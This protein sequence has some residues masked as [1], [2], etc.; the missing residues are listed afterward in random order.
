MSGRSLGLQSSWN[1]AIRLFTRGLDTDPT[2]LRRGIDVADSINQ[3]IEEFVNRYVVT[4][5][6]DNGDIT[7]DAVGTYTFQGDVVVN[8][9]TELNGELTVL[10]GGITVGDAAETLMVIA[11]DVNTTTAINSPGIR[12]GYS[13]GADDVIGDVVWTDWSTDS[14]PGNN[15]TMSVIARRRIGSGDWVNAYLQAEVF[16]D[17]HD[18]TVNISANPAAATNASG[19][20]NLYGMSKG[21]G[22][23]HITLTADDAVLLTNRILGFGGTGNTDFFQY[24]NTNSEF[25]WKIANTTT[26]L[27]LK[28]DIVY[29][30]RT[31]SGKADYNNLED[32]PGIFLFS[33]NMNTTNKVTPGV[34]FGSSDS[35]FTTEN[36][37]SLAGI[38]GVATEAYG[39]DSD[40]GMYLE[41]RVC[42]NNPGTTNVLESEPHGY[43]MTTTGFR[44]REDNVQD[45][46]S[47]GLRWDDVYATNG[48]IQTSDLREKNLLPQHRLGL[49]FMLSLD[50]IAFTRDGGTR[51]HHGVGAQHVRDGLVSVEANPA[52]HAL[53]V[54]DGDD[55]RMGVRYDELWGPQINANREIDERLSRLEDAILAL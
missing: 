5:N 1:E 41:F 21:T 24:D 2:D 50:G 49:D 17:S 13:G 46:G 37:K 10:A 32:N 34:L 47:S 42:G 7:F 26:P 8:G 18:T 16:D 38:W 4:A 6:N 25:I 3:Q 55:G 35:A 30:R 48:T 28:D 45:L 20:V 40:G 39:N 19:E 12:W 54:Q 33:G 22:T 44:S 31:T 51:I 11:P 29:I 52:D 53:W 23:G 43:L 15:M 36:P 9:A 27:R 14:P